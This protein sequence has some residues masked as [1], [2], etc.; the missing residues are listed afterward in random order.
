MRHSRDWSANQVSSTNSQG[1]LLSWKRE[2]DMAELSAHCRCDS[3]GKKVRNI[4]E[5]GHVSR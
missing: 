3:E 4:N 2:G 5:Y 1:I